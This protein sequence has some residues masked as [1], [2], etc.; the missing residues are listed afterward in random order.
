MRQMLVQKNGSIYV[1]LTDEEQEVNNEIEKE[2]VETPEII[3]KVSEMIFEDIFP[4]KKYTYPAFNGRYAFFFNQAVDDRPYK[5]NQNYDVGVRILTPWYDGSTDD[6]TLRLMS[7]QG[8]EVLVVLP[9]DAEFL[10]EIQSYLKIEGFLR[11]NTSTQ[12]AKYETIKEAKRVEMRER[13]AN[14]KLYL[15]EALKEATIYVNGDVARVSGK[16]VGT[17]INEAIGRL[18]QTVYHKL[19]YI[20]TPMGEAEIRKLLHNSNQ[21]SLGLG[22][23]LKAM[24]TRWT[25]CRALSL[26]IPAIT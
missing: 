14:A 10:K 22:A 25:M 4:G 16:E 21:L 20:D 5:A 9:S 18:V 26:S 3:T 24:L 12:L 1:F 19:S 23:A 11:K 13:S 15:T 6:A 8:K 7:G 2:N 17:R